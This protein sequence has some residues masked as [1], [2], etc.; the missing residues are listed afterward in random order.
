VP[1]LDDVAAGNGEAHA[2]HQ[3]DA[4]HF[5]DAGVLGAERVQL[6]GFTYEEKS[7]MYLRER[8][9]K[10][11][12][13]RVTGEQLVTKNIIIQKVKNYT[14]K[15]DTAGRQDVN[16]VGS[17]EGYFVTNGEYIKIKWSKKSR[18]ESTK[19]T[20]SEGKEIVL[21]QGQTWIQVVPSDGSVDIK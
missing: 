21:N 20:D 13:E 10:P 8:K 2:D 16:T 5:G 14:I 15:G 12:M 9:G 6:G 1:L 17:G 18:S 19:Y 3:A 4:A 11:H 7:K